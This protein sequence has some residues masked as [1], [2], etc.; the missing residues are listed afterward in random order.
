MEADTHH[1]HHIAAVAVGA[2][3]LAILAAHQAEAQAVAEVV[4]KS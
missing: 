1:R 3:P 4:D 2:H